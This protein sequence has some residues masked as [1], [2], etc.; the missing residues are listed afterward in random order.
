MVFRVINKGGEAG[1]RFFCENEVD[2]E[3][4]V[5]DMIKVINYKRRKY[6]SCL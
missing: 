1:F 3:K 5:E 4:Q 2:D 6:N